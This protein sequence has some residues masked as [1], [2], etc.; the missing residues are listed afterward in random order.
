MHSLSAEKYPIGSKLRA[1]KADNTSEKVYKTFIYMIFS[2]ML[3]FVLKQSSFL[4]VLFMG[5]EANPQYWINYPCQ[6]IPNYLDDLYIVKLA[7]HGYDMLE[8]LIYHRNKRDFSEMTIHHIVTVSLILFSYATN[9]LPYGSIIMLLHDVSDVFV[10][11][12]KSSLDVAS[13][14]TFITTYVLMVVSW[15]Y[16]RLYYFPFKA[17]TNFYNT[18]TTTDNTM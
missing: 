8:G 7:Y 9:Y 13:P 10:S 11:A 17:L 2:I 6:P 1:L 12:F 4:D 15:I 14:P 5:N 3:F 18:F 16:F